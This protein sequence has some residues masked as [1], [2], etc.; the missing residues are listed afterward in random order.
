MDF[1]HLSRAG[2]VQRR[3]RDQLIKKGWR[4]ICTYM[5]VEHRIALEQLRR[6]HELKTLHEALDLVLTSCSLP[7]FSESAGTSR[8]HSMG[9]SCLTAK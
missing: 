8:D 7:S 3:Y 9:L 4:P 2:D 6:R 1:S 5:R